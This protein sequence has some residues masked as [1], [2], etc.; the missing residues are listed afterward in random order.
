[1]IRRPPRSTLSSSSAASDV[2]KR[3]EYGGVSMSNM[4][5]S[6]R[7]ISTEELLK[8]QHWVLIDGKV[9]D[10]EHFDTHPGGMHILL[11][12]SAAH[13]HELSQVW[14]DYDIDCV[15]QFDE[16]GHSPKSRDQLGEFC[17]GVHRRSEH[18]I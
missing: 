1:M 8:N 14:K 13:R 16:I 3:Q 9:Y 10:I 7:A 6:E 18:P 11:Q 4:A 12:N 17:V 5:D 15:E 2:Y